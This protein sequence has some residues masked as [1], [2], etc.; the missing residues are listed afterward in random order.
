MRVSAPAL[1]AATS[2]RASACSVEEPGVAVPP[3]PTMSG[4]RLE[5]RIIAER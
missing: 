1:V 5:E 3:I 4:L 2:A